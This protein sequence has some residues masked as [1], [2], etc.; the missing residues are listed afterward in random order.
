MAKSADPSGLHLVFGGELKRLGG[1][2]FKNPEALDVVGIYP[3]YASAY[4]AWK[5]AA[6]RTVDNALMRYFIIP[7]HKLIEP[8]PPAGDVAAKR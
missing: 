3:D 4:L 1:H 8:A 7:I 5:G 2:D 6:Q